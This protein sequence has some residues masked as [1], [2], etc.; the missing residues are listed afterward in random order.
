MAIEI[1]NSLSFTSIAA[2]LPTKIKRKEKS[3]L[4]FWI[5]ILLNILERRI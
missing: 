2:N 1:T 5:S 4:Y 3:Q